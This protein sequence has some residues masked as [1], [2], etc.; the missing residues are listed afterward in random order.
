MASSSCP[1]VPARR[2][3]RRE[4]LDP[5]AAQRVLSVLNAGATINAVE[6]DATSDRYLVRSELYEFLAIVAKRAFEADKSNVDLAELEKIVGVA[7]L[8]DVNQNAE[9]VLHYMHPI[10]ED[11]GFTAEIKLSEV[12]PADV[13]TVRTVRC[14]PSKS[15][16]SPHSCSGLACEIGRAHV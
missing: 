12:A 16:K 4:R 5:H 10:S 6:Y 8:P 13:R 15:A 11:R 14:K 2:R 7:L 9:T 1:A 3:P